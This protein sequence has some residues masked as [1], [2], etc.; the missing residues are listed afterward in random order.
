MH[1]GAHMLAPEN[2][3]CLVWRRC[4]CFSDYHVWLLSKVVV[5]TKHLKWFLQYLCGTSGLETC[6]LRQSC[7]ELVSPF[8]EINLE[9]SFLVCC[10]E[11]LSKKC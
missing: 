11:L 10:V 5:P 7:G 6:P 4:L 2:M 1:R 8:W 9:M 3:H